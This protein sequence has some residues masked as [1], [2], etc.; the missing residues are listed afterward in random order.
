MSELTLLLI[1]LAFLALLWFF[2]IAAVGVIRTDL[3]GARTAA[4]PARKPTK[5]AK[6]V[7]KPKRGEP[8][9]MVVTGGPLQG[10]V[11]NL[12]E[13][14]ITIGRATDA[15]LVLSDDYASSRHARLFPQD[16]QWI[17]EDLGSTNGTYLDRSKV[18]RPTPVPLG[19]PIRIGKTVIE[20]R[21]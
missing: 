5:T 13:T 3:F 14:P 6:P 2:V 7:S 8:R 17:V 20:L 11:I 21:K 12:T 9:Q 15:T 1:R 18:T 19:V 10:T 4:A 16:G